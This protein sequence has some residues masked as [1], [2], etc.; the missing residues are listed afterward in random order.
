MKINHPFKGDRKG[1]T[2]DPE[3]VAW[4][5]KLANLPQATYEKYDKVYWRGSGKGGIVPA[6]RYTD[7]TTK[8]CAKAV[9]DIHAAFPKLTRH[10]IAI[11]L[12]IQSADQLDKVRATLGIVPT[13]GNG[14]E[15][16]APAPVKATAKKAAAPKKAAAKKAA[17]G[18]KPDVVASE[19]AARRDEARA[20]AAAKAAEAKAAKAEAKEEPKPEPD[21]ELQP[22]GTE[23]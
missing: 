15:T 7:P 11:A 9:A 10:R 4:V 1:T 16:A 21:K 20:N 19:A 12:N 3:V 14:K 6:G 23:G 5:G 17:A 18:P 2:L 13:R 8:Q 22:T